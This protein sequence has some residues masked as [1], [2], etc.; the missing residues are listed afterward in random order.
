MDWKFHYGELV[1]KV[2]YQLHAKGLD[3]ITAIYDYYQS[4]DID[5]SGQ[6]DKVEFE[7]F[8]RKVGMFLTTQELTVV[9]KHFDLNQDKQIH[10]KEFVEALRADFPDKR[11]AVVRY[12]FQSLDR[13]G[14]GALSLADLVA[15]FRAAAHPRV[16]LREKQEDRVLAEFEAGLSL[17]AD[18]DV[19]SEAAFL[20]FYADVSAC[21]PAEKDEYF[22]D[23]VLDTWG[24][25][26]TQRVSELEDI[27]YEK[28][29][30]RTHGADDEG[31]TAARVFR[32][33]DKDESGSVSFEEFNQVLEAYG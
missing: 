8:L 28:V 7:N 5:G 24:L 27:L 3:V 29:R 26:S 15:N 4:F 32:H 20:E 11:V 31:K 18:G 23:M 14:A 9:F 12:A 2:K 22:V 30:Q 17:R 33:F 10:Y 25:V 19:V 1:N 16:K 21:L 6:L 13:S